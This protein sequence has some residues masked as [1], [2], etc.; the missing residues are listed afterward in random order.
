VP[1]DVIAGTYTRVTFGTSGFT[2]NI[3]NVRW[4]GITRTAI[5][6]SHMGVAQPAPGTFGNRDYIPSGF[7]DAGELVLDVHFSPD[8]TY[9]LHTDP[10][11]ITVIWPKATADTI[12][13]QWAGMGFVRQLE[14]N[15]PMD[16]K[17]TAT[18]TLKFSG[19]ITMTPSG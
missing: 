5:D 12:A 11:L 10:E 3:T 14:I 16:E 17:M 9:P 4:S 19:A 2:A 15:D 18:L 1:Y 6:T 13:P 8:S 7:S